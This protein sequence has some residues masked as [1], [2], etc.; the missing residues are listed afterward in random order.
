MKINACKLCASTFPK[1]L[2]VGSHNKSLPDCSACTPHLFDY[3]EDD[4]VCDDDD[5]DHDDDHHKDDDDD[6]T[7]TGLQRE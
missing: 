5:H 7:L 6:K 3:D 2:I 4:D 1:E